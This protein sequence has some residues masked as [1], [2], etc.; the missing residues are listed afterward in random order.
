MRQHYISTA[1][2]QQERSLKKAV[3]E[4]QNETLKY[5]AEFLNEGDETGVQFP[6]LQPMANRATTESPVIFTTIVTKE[7][8]DAE[9]NYAV[10]K[11]KVKNLM[12]EKQ[13]PVSEENFQVILLEGRDSMKEQMGLF[14]ALIRTI[15]PGD[16][17][18]ACLTYGNKPNIAT[19]YMALEYARQCVEDVEI[20]NLVYGR[21][22]HYNEAR[23]AEIYDYSAMVYLS[24]LVNQMVEMKIKNP[25]QII[26][27][28]VGGEG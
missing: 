5:C 21:Y 15:H 23:K 12:G 16:R 11:E 28:M 26:S 7:N 10:Y 25:G 14:D 19:L 22:P 1:S 13:I 4:S 18:Q 24:S 8:P 2:L 9:R 17:I 6:I 3:Y 27:A 20:E